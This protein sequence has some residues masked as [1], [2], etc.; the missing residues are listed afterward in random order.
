LNNI[1]KNIL[2][3]LKN[4]IYFNKNHSNAQEIL[5]KIFDK[6]RKPE[7][8]NK[9]KCYRQNDCECIILGYLLIDNLIFSNAKNESFLIIK[10]LDQYFMNP[11]INLPF[12]LFLKVIRI[13][14]GQLKYHEARSLIENY[15]T[16]SSLP[17]SAKTANVARK[18]VKYFK[19]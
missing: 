2:S 12:K 13:Y 15:M 5:E 11:D 14:L 18:S 4:E 10:K 7:N 17:S 19:I 1:D 6:L 16:Y 3:N 9:H 8:K